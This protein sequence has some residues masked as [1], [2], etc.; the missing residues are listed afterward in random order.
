ME[1]AATRFARSP[2]QILRDAVRRMLP[3]NKLGRRMLMKLKTYQGPDH[4]HQAQNPQPLERFP[5][6]Q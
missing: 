6:Q 5:G 4:P 3:K 1:N 2:E